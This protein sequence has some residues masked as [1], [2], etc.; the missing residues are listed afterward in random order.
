MPKGLTREPT[1]RGGQTPGDGRSRLVG[2]GSGVA[3]QRGE[4]P[5]TDSRSTS[6]AP[7]GARRDARGRPSWG[8][9]AALRPRFVAQ[10]DAMQAKVD[11]VKVLQ[12]APAIEIAAS[13]PLF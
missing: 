1:P 7:R 10:F 11:A 5:Q 6:G 8:R 4:G 12:T 13:F 2:A 3:S 9:A